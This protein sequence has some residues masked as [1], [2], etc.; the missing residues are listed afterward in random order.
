MLRRTREL[1]AG[2]HI[3]RQ[4]VAEAAHTLA[5]LLGAGLTPLAAW[6]ELAERERERPAQSTARRRGR[7]SEGTTSADSRSGAARVERMDAVAHAIARGGEAA[8]AIASL[9][10]GWQPLAAA[11]FVAGAAGAPLGP[12]LRTLAEGL[13]EGAATADDVRVALAEPAGTARLMAWLPLVALG[14]GAMLGF[15]SFSTL[16]S[17]PIGWALAALGIALMLVAARWRARLV[18]RAQPAAAVPGLDAEMLALALSGGCAIPRA[19]ALVERA[20]VDAGLGGASPGTDAVLRL[21][22]RAGAPAAELLRAEAGQMRRRARAEG[23]ERAAALGTSLLLPL[24][25]CTLPAF[26]V[27][28]VVPLIVSVL[29]SSGLSLP[30]GAA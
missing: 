9:G 25:L 26:L 20:L 30:A 15:D 11:W 13:R 27:L 14:L 28:G 16:T 2:S 21:S 4:A 7:P 18:R 10:P 3:D 12:A 22:A 8:P 5:V 29:Q 23:R 17:T 19:H 1:G 6:R 24:G